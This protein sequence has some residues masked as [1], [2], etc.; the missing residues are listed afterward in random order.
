MRWE[1]ATYIL[2]TA[3]HL[4]SLL[5]IADIEAAAAAKAARQKQLLDGPWAFERKIGENRPGKLDWPVG[6]GVSPNADTIAIADHID[7]VQVYSGELVH[8]YSLKTTQGLKAGTWSHPKEVIVSSDGICY[9]TDTTQFVKQY[10]VATGVYK[11]RWAA[12][13]PQHKPSDAEDTVL[14]GLTMDTKGQLLVGEVRKKYISEHKVDGV[15]VASIKVGIEPC[16]LAVTSQDEIILSNC[17]DTVHIVDNTGQ[18]LHTVKR[19]S[20]V[21]WWNPTGVTCYEDIICICNYVAKSIHCYSVSGDYLG[22]IPISIPGNPTCLAI[23]PDG[24]QLMVLYWGFPTDGA[25]AVYKFQA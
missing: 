13:S 12:V 22:D 21:Q 14:R 15:H 17:A 8:K 19:P 16:S 4:L 24:K 25:V 1:H 18:L 20:H 3:P 6:I 2:Y 10:D 11:G 9:L 23:T 7:R 5:Q